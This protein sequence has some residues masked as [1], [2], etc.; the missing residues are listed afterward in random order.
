D[1]GAVPGA[2]GDHLLPVRLHHRHLGRWLGKAADR[3]GVDRHPAG[4][5]WWQLLLHRNAAAAMAEGHPVQ[6]CGVPDQWLPLEFLRRLG[7][8]RRHQ[9]GDDPWLSRRLPAGG[10]V[11]IQDGVSVEELV[12]KRKRPQMRAFSI[13]ALETY[14]PNILPRPST[15]SLAWVTAWTFSSS[16][17]PCSVA[18][19]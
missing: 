1:D 17:A 3:P 15:A 12:H 4:V 16:A 10:V 5:P 14:L 2:D 13:T 6:P 8:Q 7:H 19:A 9:P 18:L 11:D